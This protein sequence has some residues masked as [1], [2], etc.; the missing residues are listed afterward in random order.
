VTSM[1]H[2]LQSIRAVGL[3]CRFAFCVPLSASL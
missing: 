1:M 3:M 2:D